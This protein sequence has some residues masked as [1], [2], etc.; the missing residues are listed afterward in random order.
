MNQAWR[1]EAG[2]T[3]GPI[4][5]AGRGSV[6]GFDDL[7]LSD[8]GVDVADALV[9]H[10]EADPDKPTRLEFL[11]VVQVGGIWIRVDK[12]GKV[13]AGVKAPKKTGMVPLKSHDDSTRWLGF[14]L[15][16]K[17]PHDIRP[18]LL[19]LVWQRN[20]IGVE[21]C[22]QYGANYLLAS[23]HDLNMDLLQAAAADA[24]LILVYGETRG[25]G[26]PKAKRRIKRHRPRRP[27]LHQRERQFKLQNGTWAPLRD[28]AGK[29]YRRR[30]REAVAT[31]A[32]IDNWRPTPTGRN[33]SRG[34]AE[35]EWLPNSTK[36]EMTGPMAHLF[37]ARHPTVPPTDWISGRGRLTSA[38]RYNGNQTNHHRHECF[39]SRSRSG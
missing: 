6:A 35:P 32:A 34:F 33:F 9:F 2:A 22:I 16:G 18:D 5:G 12:N 8:A 20:L 7:A 21:R 28:A 36:V 4:F 13:H 38:D 30:Y 24:L 15:T 19:A 11:P 1:G 29:A 23:G 27:T 37:H 3:D 25:D 17:G 31:F 14:A 10:E 26:N 39:V